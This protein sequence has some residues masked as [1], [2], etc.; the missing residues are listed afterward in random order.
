MNTLRNAVFA[1]VCIAS[2][3]ATM[4]VAAP[5]TPADAGEAA[6]A[7][8]RTLSSPEFGGRAPGTPGSRLAQ[9]YITGRFKELGLA[10]F[11]ASY[12][13]PFTFSRGRGEGKG[14]PVTGVNL[15]AQ[16][17]GSTHPERTIVIS[18]HYDHLGTHKGA[19]YLGAD[20][21]ASGVAAM[22]AVAAHFKQH[23][24]ANTI[25]FAAFDAEEGGLRGARAFVGAAPFPLKQVAL[26]INFDMVSRNDANEIYVT[27]TRYTPALKALVAR[28]AAGSAVKV[29][30]GHDSQRP[31]KGPD[32]DWTSSSDH[33]AFHKAGIAFLYYGVEDHADYHKPSDTFDKIKPKFF[34]EVVRMLVASAD[35]MDKNLDALK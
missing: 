22:L 23:P 17:R 32:D 5:A 27:G 29:I 30:P 9:E 15:I 28:G 3:L 13:M 7:D 6:L 31:G 1:A 19:T 34:T 8:V 26:N 20:D 35:L 21:N 33:G 16:I 25:V 2:L 18:A 24:P 11:G 10:S 4:A 14:E 12:A